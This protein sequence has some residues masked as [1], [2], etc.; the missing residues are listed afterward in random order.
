MH[1]SLNPKR[2]FEADAA[3]VMLTKYPEG[4]ANALEKTK[5]DLRTLSVPRVASHLFFVTPNSMNERSILSSLMSG[6]SPRDERIRILR[7][8]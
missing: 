1:L 5:H 7:S 3:G 8:M 2:E 4:L 6:H